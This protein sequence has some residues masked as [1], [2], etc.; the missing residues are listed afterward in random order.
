MEGWKGVN[1]FMKRFELGV[2]KFSNFRG[3]SLNTEAEIIRDK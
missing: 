3:F 2:V 1:T